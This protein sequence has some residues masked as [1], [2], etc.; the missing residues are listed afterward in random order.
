MDLV[1][2]RRF[3]IAMIALL[4]CGGGAVVFAPGWAPLWVRSRW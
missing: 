1:G 2:G 4:A 3:G